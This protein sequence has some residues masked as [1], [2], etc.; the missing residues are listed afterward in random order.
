[1][2][3]AII[4]GSSGLVGSEA[5]KYFASTGM[6]VVGIDNG[7]GKSPT[8]CRIFCGTSSN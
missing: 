2:S 8:M 4:S 6:D 3:V 7:I 1:M 5:V